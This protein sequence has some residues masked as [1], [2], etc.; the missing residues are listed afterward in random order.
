[1]RKDRGGGAGFR[2]FVQLGARE[3]HNSRLGGRMDP[4]SSCAMNL[5][6]SDGAR[7]AWEAISNS[8]R[9]LIHCSHQ[10]SSLGPESLEHI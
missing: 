7:D 3:E 8:R 5:G 9:S 1:M 6:L 10:L 2:L 4:P